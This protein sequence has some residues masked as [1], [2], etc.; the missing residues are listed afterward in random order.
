[1]IK[2]LSSLVTFPLL[3]WP[4]SALSR[5]VAEGIT[6][7][8]RSPSDH[9]VSV[10]TGF[11]PQ[12]DITVWDDGE[13]AVNGAERPRVTKAEAV[14][15]RN[16]LARFRSTANDSVDPST[17][18]PNACLLKVQWPERAHARRPTACGNFMYGRIGAD[19][20]SLFGGVR[21]VLKAVHLDISGQPTL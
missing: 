3:I 10:C 9:G 16:I 14:R 15:F 7:A 1:M 18:W 4:A 5:S 6:I 20:T 21:S 8:L 12:L 2:G 13:V 19:K 17:V 11:C